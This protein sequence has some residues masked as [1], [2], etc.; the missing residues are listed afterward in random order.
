MDCFTLSCIVF[1]FI[2]PQF[3]DLI[4]SLVV[5]PSAFSRRF[6]CVT[7]SHRVAEFTGTETLLVVHKSVHT[8]VF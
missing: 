2:F 1:I 8:A 3:S 5:F 6:C 4:L 7:G